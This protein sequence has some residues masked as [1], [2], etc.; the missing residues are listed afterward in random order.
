MQVTHVKPIV[1]DPGSRKNWLFVTEVAPS[2][3]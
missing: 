3:G 1:V 2:Q